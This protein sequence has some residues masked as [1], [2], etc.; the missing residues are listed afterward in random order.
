MKNI[1]EMYKTVVKDPFPSEMTITLG[2]QVLKFA[3]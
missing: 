1:K 3:R 2:D